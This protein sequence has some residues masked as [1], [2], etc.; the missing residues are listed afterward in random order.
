MRELLMEKMP[1]LAS[2]IHQQLEGEAGGEVEEVV[3]T[4]PG[5]VDSAWTWEDA[6]MRLKAAYEKNG[7]SGWAEA[8][9]KEVEAEGEQERLRRERLMGESK[10]V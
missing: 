6:E 7:F 5:V 3:Q 2:R 10:L 8:A 1:T 9:L 4:I